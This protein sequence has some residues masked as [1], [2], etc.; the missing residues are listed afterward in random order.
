MQEISF[1]QLLEATRTLRPEQRQALAQVLRLGTIAEGVFNSPADL[2]ADALLDAEVLSE[3]GAYS[4]FA[5][6][7][8]EHTAAG[9][10]ADAELFA[11]SQCISCE[12]EEE[13]V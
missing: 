6:L 8:T 10:I 2:Y 5:P 7:E 11:A 9:T 1:D 13:D 12:W 3:A 4:V